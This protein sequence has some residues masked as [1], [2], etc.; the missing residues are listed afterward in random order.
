MPKYTKKQIIG[1]VLAVV[2]CAVIM[3]LPTPEALTPQAMSVMAVFIAAVILWVFDT[4]PLFI[5]ALIM[6]LLWIIIGKLPITTVFYTFSAT[7]FWLVLGAL[8][9]GL[10]V[11]ESGL[12]KRMAMV[13]MK[14]FP[15]T[16]KGQVLALLLTGTVVSPVVPSTMAKMAIAAPMSVGISEGLG[17]AKGSKPTAGLFLAS[18]AGYQLTAPAFL[19]ASFMSYM[20]LGLISSEYSAHFTWINWF[21]AMIPYLVI[22]IIG[23]YITIPRM[24][25]PKMTKEEVAEAAKNLK[26][27]DLGPMTYREKAALVITLIALVM[28]ITESVHGI[29]SALVSVAAIC[30]FI[31]FGVI[32]PA[33]YSK[34]MNWNLL[35]FI[36]CVLCA[37]NV[38]GSVGIDAWLVSLIGPMFSAVSGNIYLFVVVVIVVCY[39]SRLLIAEMTTAMSVTLILLAPIAATAGY[40]P[41]VVGVVIYASAYT[42]NTYYQNS[43]FIVSHGLVGGE[44]VVNWKHCRPAAIAFMI[45]NFVGLIVSVP[46]WQI[47]GFC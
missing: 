1:L 43:S 17:F 45:I 39:V 23:W 4:F 20:L 30:L 34:K 15:K 8:G 36:T 44:E 40:N 9:I 13:L 16:Y 21:L 14:L 29:G 42:W 31:I 7:N 18:Y 35:F 2:A 47:L 32:S 33:D 10:A 11:G 3:L 5:T 28:W 12:V 22:T 37:A 41:W 24:Y 19:S 6:C 25:A 26:T 27:Q 38:M 46:F